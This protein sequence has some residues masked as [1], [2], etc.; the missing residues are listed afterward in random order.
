MVN[1]LGNGEFSSESIWNTNLIQF[2]SPVNVSSTSAIYNALSSSY[3]M[4][5]PWVLYYLL[6][7]DQFFLIGA[8]LHSII[9]LRS[10][11]IKNENSQ[12]YML[13]RKIVELFLEDKNNVWEIRNNDVQASQGHL[14]RNA[15]N[16]NI[17]KLCPSEWTS[18][19]NIEYERCEK[20]PQKPPTFV[21]VADI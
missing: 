3:T 13:V 11:M 16:N 9:L 2:T 14:S 17:S 8:H 5:T 4:S 12:D 10:N 20:N 6:L 21:T 1:S 18:N 15:I 7:S 19:I